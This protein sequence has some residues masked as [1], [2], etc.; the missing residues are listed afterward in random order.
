MVDNA[1]IIYF[2]DVNADPYTNDDGQTMMGQN[3]TE[4]DTKIGESNYD[5]G[6]VFSTGGGGIAKRGVV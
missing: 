1:S 6:H 4:I 2:G 5:I 3:Q